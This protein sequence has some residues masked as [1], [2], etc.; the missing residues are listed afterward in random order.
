MYQILGGECVGMTSV[1]EVVLAKELGMCYATIGLVTNEAAGIADHPLTHEEV[2]ENMKV[3][4]KTVAALLPEIFRL[5]RPEQDCRCP[6]GNAEA[7]KF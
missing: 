1:P 7:G 2:I 4:G 5:F 3:T 6:L